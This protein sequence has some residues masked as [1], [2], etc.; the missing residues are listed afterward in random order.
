MHGRFLKVVG[1]A[2]D[3]YAMAFLFPVLI[4]RKIMVVNLVRIVHNCWEAPYDIL[5]FG[6][7]RGDHPFSSP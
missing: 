3:H 6:C 5:C 2:I 4:V 1:S 7:P